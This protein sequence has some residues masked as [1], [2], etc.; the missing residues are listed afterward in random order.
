[1]VMASGRWLGVRLDLLASMLTGAVSLAA[2]L[3]S[4]DAGRCTCKVNQSRSKKKETIQRTCHYKTTLAS[5]V[6]E[7]INIFYIIFLFISFLRLVEEYRSD[8]LRLQFRFKLR[9]GQFSLV[10]GNRSLQIRQPLII[11]HRF[12]F[13]L[14]TKDSSPWNDICMTR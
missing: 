10:K 4:Q 2:V 3:V 6:I 12:V 1:M 8:L 5:F 11:C 7:L 14:L 13:R 9:H